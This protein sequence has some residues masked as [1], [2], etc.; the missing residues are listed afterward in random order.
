ML[1]D[2]DANE[3]TDL[4]AQYV[5]KFYG[6]RTRSYTSYIELSNQYLEIPNVASKDAICPITK[7]PVSIL[8]E[9]LIEYGFDEQDLLHFEMLLNATYNHDNLKY[10]NKSDVIIYLQRWV[11]DLQ[12][13]LQSLN[14]I[15]RVNNVV[16]TVNNIVQT[17]SVTG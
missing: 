8:T 7:L 2:R 10:N 16:Q 13:Q 15:T 6:S 1:F 17:V 9:K 14:T 12:T 11:D 5:A 4:L 3:M